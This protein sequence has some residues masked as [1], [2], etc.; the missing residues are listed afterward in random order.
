MSRF[1]TNIVTKRTH[2]T[3]DEA[4]IC[5]KLTS[6]EFDRVCAMTD[7]H[8]TMP[9]KQHLT[10]LSTRMQYRLVDIHRMRESEIYKKMH[11]KVENREKKK[12]YAASGREY[13]I[14]Y[15]PDDRTDY[16]KIILEKYPSFDDVYEDLGE[17]L[18]CLI[19][20]ERVVR[21]ARKLCV[22]FETDILAKVR[23]ELSLFYLYLAVS[24]G[25]YQVFLTNS[26]VHY[27]TQVKEAEVFW[28][29]AYPIV[30]EE[31]VLGINYNAVVNLVEFNAY[32]LEK[33]NFNLFKQLS[34]DTL[35]HIREVRSAGQPPAAPEKKTPAA[36][37]PPGTEPAI[38][39]KGSF[40]EKTVGEYHREFAGK[41]QLVSPRRL[42]AGK[43]FYVSPCCNAL[44]N[45][46]ELLI[47]AGSGTVVP[48]STD[49]C[50]VYL[51]TQIPPVFNIQRA[52]AHPQLVYDSCNLGQL[53]DAGIYRPGQ[54]L[55]AHLCPFSDPLEQTHLDTFNISERKKEKLEDI[56]NQ[57]K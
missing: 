17:C 30:D 50:D 52:Y 6:D 51:C 16:A 47:L 7:T 36:G 11:L 35:G 29:E 22:P 46:L 31:D 1:Y 40:G 44:T 5:L 25:D 53:Q 41:Y 28:K 19:F 56:I 15:L 4:L 10:N 23:T 57:H 14:K 42:F 27:Q 8:P 33:I 9:H 38:A 32:L 26:G 18:S 37:Q 34:G 24:G 2:V 55:P 49:L 21:Y 45:S 43:S 20:G 54:T 13:K 39:Q 3:R 48:A 12:G